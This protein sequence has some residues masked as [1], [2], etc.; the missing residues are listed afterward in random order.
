MK[1]VIIETPFPTTEEVVR[2]LRITP[3]RFE[4]IRMIVEE[5]RRKEA[6]H[7]TKQRASHSAGGRNAK[8]ARS[9]SR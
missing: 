2:D 8:R 3:E 9:A 6:A 1:R 5:G 4:K 7:S